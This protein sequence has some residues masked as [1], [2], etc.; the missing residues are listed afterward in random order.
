VRI[1][2][3]RQYAIT[4]IPA[5]LTIG[6]I[7]IAVAL[8]GADRATPRPSETDVLVSA[9]INHQMPNWANV[10]GVPNKLRRQMHLPLNEPGVMIFVKD[11]RWHGDDTVILMADG[12]VYES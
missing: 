4:T 8:H 5:V 6:A 12:N 7:S 10:E 11:K 9:Y 1:R 2:Q 3:L